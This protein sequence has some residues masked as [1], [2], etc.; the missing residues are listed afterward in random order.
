M[1][2]KLKRGMLVRWVVDYGY[3]T[4]SVTGDGVTPH[5]PLYLYG[6]VIEVSRKDPN[7]V[8]IVCTS[9]GDW[10]LLNMIHDRFEIV[11]DGGLIGE[12]TEG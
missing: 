5:D 10:R 1:V 7:S 4:A 8:A 3:F 6:I 12:T 9:H 2:T 11:S